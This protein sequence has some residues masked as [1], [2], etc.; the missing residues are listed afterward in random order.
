MRTTFS[1]LI[2]ALFLALA[3]N[4]ATARP[5]DT[6]ISQLIS[7]GQFATAQEVLAQGD[8]SELDEL[9]FIARVFKA[10]GR[11]EEAVAA[12]VE[13]L[14][15]DPNYIN[16]R[17]ELAHTLLTTGR[18]DA[19]QTQLDMLKR[20]DSNPQMQAG[21]Q[22]MLSIIAQNRPFGISGVFAFLP[23][24]NINKGTSNTVFDTVLGTLVIDPESRPD[25]GVGLQLGVSGYF[26][27][28]INERSR[29]SL[30]WSAAQNFYQ[31][32]RNASITGEISIPYEV[33]F[34]KGGFSLAPYYRASWGSLK[35]SDAS[36][37]YGDPVYIPA[38]YAEN[39]FTLQATGLR[40]A[41]DWRVSAQ[42]RLALALTYE[43]RD[44]P[45]ASYQNGAFSSETLRFSRQISPSLSYQI[46]ATFEQSIPFAGTSA[47]LAYNGGKLFA[48]VNKA[49]DGGL[50]T[51]FG[52][53]AGY[54]QFIG[55]FPLTTAPRADDFYGVNFSLSHARVQIAGFVPSLRCDYTLNTS[56]VAFFDF[57]VVNCTIGISKEF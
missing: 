12:L 10:T 15:R 41:A 23:S 38:A 7:Q 26:R 49:W 31:N 35:T 48:S 28:V 37:T 46:G 22:Q 55:D 19:A 9:F 47:H 1:N 21:Y 56:N 25:S 44:Y 4:A 57:E 8:P 11:A 33:R 36:G 42:N 24:T 32:P 51:G 18:Y 50:R 20:V 17:R 2:I 54:R 14:N 45:H 39:A 27:K 29:I 40:A 53:E 16:A 52:L 34:A 13:I 30:Q 43:E 6:L 5:D 3:G